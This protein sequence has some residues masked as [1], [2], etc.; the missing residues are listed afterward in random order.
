MPTPNSS[1]TA[2]A[3]FHDAVQRVGLTYALGTALDSI[4]TREHDQSAWMLNEAHSRPEPG[5]PHPDP[6]MAA[7]GWHAHD[8][9]MWV[10]DGNSGQ[11][12]VQ[13]LE[14]YAASPGHADR[15]AG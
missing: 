6:A 3:A 12:D 14:R 5:I 13:A 1:A 4:Q 11:G 2:E 7:L 8:C 15:E 10:R 9:G